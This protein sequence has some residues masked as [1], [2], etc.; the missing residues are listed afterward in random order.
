MSRRFVVSLSLLCLAAWCAVTISCGSSNSS[1]NNHAC[2][3]GPYNVVGDWQIS[4]SANGASTSGYG[5]IDSNGL[6]LFFDNSVTNGSGETLAPPTITGNCSFSGNTTIYA[7]PGEPVSPT[8]VTVATQGNVTSNSSISGTLSGTTT[9]SFTATPFSPLT[10]TPAALTDLTF[11]TMEGAFPA[12]GISLLVTFTAS[13]SDASMSFTGTGAACTVNGT[14]TQV[15]TSNVFDVSMTYSGASC[16]VTGT[17]TGLGFESSS[18]YFGFNGNG[19]GTYLYADML[20]SGG[21]F[22]MEF[23]P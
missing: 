22:V 19:T 10:G 23:F 20:Y 4:V 9:G 14:F 6:A 7:E 12:G 2:T 11:G 3:G 16:P 17:M 5:A 1:N 15:S 13:G 21:P 18:D 8:S